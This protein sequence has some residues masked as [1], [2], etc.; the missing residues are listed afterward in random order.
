MLGLPVLGLPVL[1]FVG[2]TTFAE[3]KE[4][5]A[6]G[7]WAF[8]PVQPVT[9]P[10]LA[11]RDAAARNAVDAFVLARLEAVGEEHSPVVPLTL[12]PPAS[13]RELLRRLTLDLHGLPPTPEEVE[14]FEKDSRPDAYEICVDRL[15]ASP[16]YGER[17]GR[18]WLDLVRYAESDGF[19]TDRVRPNAWRYR[20]YV[21]AALNADKPYDR[22]A[23]EQLAGDE[24]SPLDSEALVATGFL[25]HWPLEDNGRDLA[26][27]WQTALSDVTDVTGQVFLGLTL[28]CARCHD[29]KF[30]PIPQQDYYRFQAFFAAMTP[31]NDLPVGSPEAVAKFRAAQAR[32]EVATQELRDT[33]RDFEWPYHRAAQVAR[34]EKFP[35]AIQRMVV[36][37]PEKRS[38][39]E[40]QILLLG[41][42][43][44]RVKQKDIVK[45]MPAEA[46][47][48]WEAR[49]EEIRKFDA[50]RPAPLPL[51]R[52]VQE[53]SPV[54][55]PTRLP[56]RR[57]GEFDGLDESAQVVQPGF[58]TILATAGAEELAATRPAA[59]TTGSRTAL[60]RWI[61]DE[62]NPLAARV[63]VNRLW[64]QHFSRGLVPT[65]SDFGRQG[66]PPSHPHLLDWL[67]REAFL[68]RWSLKALHRILVT[69]NVYRQTSLPPK[70]AAGWQV[71]P[72]N[73]LLWH[74]NP[75]RLEAEAI[76]DAILASSG[77]LNLHMHGESVFPVLPATLKTGYGWKPT[78]PASQQARRTIYLAVKR[79]LRVPFL[80]M[81]DV[82]DSHS[83][84]ARRALTTT[85]P[86][87]LMLL[88]DSWVLAR[89][90]AFAG[91]V[92]IATRQDL[93]ETAP[94]EVLQRDW[95]RRAYELALSR[96]PDAHE[97]RVGLDFLRRQRDA[98]QPRMEAGTAVAF[99][100]PR[101]SF[102]DLA[103]AAAL[104]DYCHAL[105][106]TNEF[107]YVD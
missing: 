81:F 87:A 59:H 23:L 80:E 60:A 85:A 62:G 52:G 73:R 53:L 51:A 64:Q 24:I 47:K 37:R 15:L 70:D 7:H 77:E 89:A 49:E 55:P 42:N 27:M 58:P 104:V 90:Q 67:A 17:W 26:G 92:I 41:G 5:A 40:R 54:A 2:R 96:S 69:S 8:R 48:L 50:L 25:R 56:P 97:E 105:W 39:L 12:S 35:K 22:F 19:K 88:N 100:R 3:A 103:S 66:S 20:D 34:A 43:E 93:G 21:I 45:R 102:N 61:T 106:N 6:D 30:D 82:P 28:G 33:Q 83:S 65:A 63:L 9:P 4:K 31:T 95:I 91:R 29:H 68:Q 10:Q 101:P 78:E 76:R 1:G 86:Q 44:L 74:A 36:K 38:I 14:D 99:P 18:H 107:L 16:R 72:E 32:W 75:Q 13:R 98:I 79:N 11:A 46:R 71:D 94:A 57:A 84:C